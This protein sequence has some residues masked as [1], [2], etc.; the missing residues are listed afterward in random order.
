VG[1]YVN[2]ERSGHG[3]WT[4]GAWTSAATTEEREK[5]DGEWQSGEWHGKGTYTS[6]NGD[7]YKGKYENGQRS[8]H[9]TWTSAITTTGTNSG[10]AKS[11]YEGEWQAGKKHGKGKCQWFVNGEL[12]STYEGDYVE[13]KRHGR[14]TYSQ[15]QDPEWDWYQYVG[16]W[17]DGQRE[18]VGI[19][20]AKGAQ[21][22]TVYLSR[23]SYDAVVGEGVVWFHSLSEQGVVEAYY[24]E[25][26]ETK[27]RVVPPEDAIVKAGGLCEK[28]RVTEENP[29]SVEKIREWLTRE[30][31]SPGLLFS[32]D[33]DAEC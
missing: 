30:W 8:G 3:A 22:R 26:G 5:Y 9:G 31:L 33:G 20:R 21:R 14:G 32:P 23:F 12:E 13:D 27:G 7:V 10:S 1:K 15:L 2:G 17:Q 11:E 24:L 25:N 16:E 29:V 18:G 28:I 6:A 4:S 19:V